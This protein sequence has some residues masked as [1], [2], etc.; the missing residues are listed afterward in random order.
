MKANN[1]CSSTS[2]PLLRINRTGINYKRI[3]TDK[4]I[5]ELLEHFRDD[6]DVM[7]S[8]RKQ[9]YNVMRLFFAW[10]INQGIEW[11]ELGI[12]H[13]IKYK[14]QL[15]EE[16]KTIRTIRF[17]LVVIKIFW[18]WLANNGIDNNIAEGIKL[19]RKQ[20]TFSKKALTPEQAKELITAIDITTVIGK[21]DY[22][23]FNLLFITG[24]RSVSVEAINIGDITEHLGVDVV[25]YKNKGSR[26]KDRFKPLTPKCLDAIETYLL[27]REGFQDSWPLFAIHAVSRKGMRLGRRSMR[28]IFHKRLA[29][30][31][32]EDKLITLHS[33]RHTHGVLSTKA[34]GA[35]ETQLSLGHASANTTRIYNQNADEDIILINR[36]GKAIDAL[37]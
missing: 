36:A 27:T 26:Q 29:N 16:A 33:T 7:L 17:Y 21:R 19:P 9:Y 18:K 10:I 3:K 23:L 22:A 28:K 25:W 31:G 37:L 2:K 32:I 8:T 5:T 34:V 13:I 6:Q 30:I 35:Y 20:N 1:L 24:L 4:D 12:S 14:D 11:R 15:F